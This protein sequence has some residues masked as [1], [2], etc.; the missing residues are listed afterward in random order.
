MFK[1]SAL[2]LLFT[3]VDLSSAERYQIKEHLGSVSNKSNFLLCANIAAVGVDCGIFSTENNKP[4]LLLS[5]HIKN[6]DIGTDFT[7][8]IT[9]LLAQ[10]QDAYSMTVKYACFSGPGVPSANQDYLEHWRLPY[11]VDAKKIIAQNNLTS[12]IIVNDFM[13][14]SYGV[15]FV[16][17]K[18]ITALH[19]AP[20]E[21]HGRR[22]II[23]AGAGLGTVS[24][25]WNEKQQAYTSFPAEAGTG[26][27]PPFD[28]FELEL[29]LRMK[30]ARD[31][32]TNHWAFFVAEPGIQYTY[33]I[34]QDMNY[35]G[36]AT[37]KKY[38]DAMA[39][40]A[41][42]NNDACCAKTAELFYK[43]YARF[44]YNFV[45]TSLPF[46]GIYLVGQTATE[47]PEMLASIFLPEYFNCVESKRPLLQ[48]IPIYIIKDD[49]SVGLY[50]TA[51]YFLLE[52]KELL[53]GSSFLTELQIKV[54]SY[55]D[56][57]KNKLRACC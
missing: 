35:E 34:L 42:V 13:A 50:G 10:L 55:W 37:D 4:V 31:F 40:L 54:S 56:V 9:S 1:K 36:C 32:K 46:G 48:R 49:V 33:Q 23:G 16:D 21:H 18:K 57:V 44:I 25:I 22:V 12:A 6:E 11:V 14:M 17:N 19:D 38:S 2:L 24:M 7:S 5:T 41:D 29:S 47:H 45:W 27:F 53:G 28:A 30:K 51:Q 52:K 26:D 8:A 39:I 20:A 43:F 3:I 15:N